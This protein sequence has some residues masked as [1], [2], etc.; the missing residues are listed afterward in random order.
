MGTI[1]Y[2]TAAT[3]LPYVYRAT[4]GGVTFSANLTATNVFDYFTDTAVVDDAIYFGSATFWSDLTINVGT[5]LSGT[6]VVLAWEYYNGSAWVAMT[7]L[8]DNTVGFTVTGSNTI[9]FPWQIN[10]SIVTVNSIA[11]YVFIRCR[12]VSLTAITEGGAN[13]TAPAKYHN[14]LI[15]VTDYTDL[16]PCTFTD[17]Y[18]WMTANHPECNVTKTN[19]IFAFPQCGFSFASRVFTTK[20]IIF[21]GSGQ[22]D[23]TAP[24][25]N[26]Y[27]ITA[28]YR[29]G[30]IGVDGSVF[31]Y[32][33]GA[34]AA[35]AFTT[36]STTKMYGTTFMALNSSYLAIR[37]GEFVD[38]L[39]DFIT[40]NYQLDAGTYIKCIFR[41]ACVLSQPITGSFTN[42]SFYSAGQIAY[43]YNTGFTLR[44]PTW[45]AAYFFYMYQTYQDITI[46]LVNPNPAL[47]DNGDI[48]T[49]VR[50]PS[51]SFGNFAKCW[52]YD[53]SLGTY[54][55]YTT[56]LSNATTNDVPIN[57]DVGDILYCSQASTARNFIPALEVTCANLSND[58][59]YAI[60]CYQGGAWRT[61]AL[62]AD[63]ALNFTQNGEVWLKN[64]NQAAF[65]LLTV[66]G[67]SG[68][69][70]RLRIV[71][72]G[73]GTPTLTKMRWKDAAGSSDWR[74]NEQYTL[75]VNVIDKDSTAIE[76]A[77]VNIYDATDTLLA[78]ATTDANGDITQQDITVG[79]YVLSP[80]DYTAGD[81]YIKKTTTNPITIKIF[82][83]GY[84]TYS[85]TSSLLEKTALTIKLRHSLSQ[86]RDEMAEAFK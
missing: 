68:S 64:V 6:D 33:G 45:N 37:D 24:T 40:G 84:E 28:G 85:H 66:N 3:N 52:F 50:I 43:A 36:S 72:K 57:G 25:Y 21:C 60:E 31:V 4:G 46:N 86:G 61:V 27:Y 26:L 38:C 18:N 1:A 14:G 71:T 2:N 5:A 65:T 19:N 30:D 8:T 75:D 42:C 79:Y 76:S 13:Q 59:V 16:A 67:V 15:A 44:D 9:V 63:G 22:L 41:G 32:N 11:N 74:I 35:A 29:Y 48:D 47:A 34:T 82:K 53:D 23:S 70:I 55:D 58:Y 39:A 77:T 81:G 83:D 69:W 73:T 54:T 20:E 78:T 56:A 17:I 51:L 80:L 10:M 62:L 49:F 12:I 7:D